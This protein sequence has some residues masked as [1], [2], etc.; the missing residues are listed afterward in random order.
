MAREAHYRC[1]WKFSGFSFP[2]DSL[3]LLLGEDL[4]QRLEIVHL[5][6]HSQEAFTLTYGGKLVGKWIC[7]A[8]ASS[9]IPADGKSIELRPP[10]EPL[11]LASYGFLLPPSVSSRITPVDSWGDEVAISFEHGN[12]LPYHFDEASGVLKH[13]MN[14]VVRHEFRIGELKEGWP[15]TI[16]FSSWGP[17]GEKTSEITYRLQSV[18]ELPDVTLHRSDFVKPG[19]LQILN[20]DGVQVYG[21]FQPGKLAPWAEWGQQMALG[22]KVRAKEQGLWASPSL[23][24]GIVVLLAAIGGA[25]VTFRRKRASS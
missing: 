6:T 14:K 19:V 18:K 24:I 17:K 13:W 16:G 12:V 23:V 25:I 9:W 20:K 22:Q 8:D 10:D 3:K 11:S 21:D 15:S 7:E 2:A 4:R 5:R 1:E